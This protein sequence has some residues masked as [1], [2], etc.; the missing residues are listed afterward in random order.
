MKRWIVAGVCVG[1]CVAGVGLWLGLSGC[2]PAAGEDRSSRLLA[3]AA[4]EAGQIVDVPQRLTR[5]L[6]IADRQSQRGQNTNASKSLAA[7]RKTLSGA[8][9]GDGL[10]TPIA[11]AGYVSISQLARRVGDTALAAG[12][13]E[14]ALTAL[15][16]I[17][18]AEHRVPY[19]Y[20]LSAELKQLHGNDASAKLVR[21]AGP[22]AAA[23]DDVTDRRRVLVIFAGS[24]FDGEDYDGGLAMLRHEG[25]P[26]WRAD[27]LEDMADAALRRAAVAK[28]HQSAAAYDEVYHASNAK[29]AEFPAAGE[30]RRESNRPRSYAVPVN[31]N[32]KENFEGRDKPTDQ[33]E[34]E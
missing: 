17:E 8:A 30:A 34:R 7:A 4:E 15:R 19:V 24:L 3:L 6:N 33:P 27:V 20:G 5:Q 23:I 28:A 12:A 9:P 21:E 16:K 18:P 29:S 31:L 32:Y 2:G 13:C 11:M 22:W 14:D 26:A 1:L 25:D 10:G